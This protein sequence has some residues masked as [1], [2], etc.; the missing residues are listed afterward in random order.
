L[1]WSHIRMVLFCTDFTLSRIWWNCF[2][3]P[4]KTPGC[5]L[6]TVL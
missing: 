4:G 5:I 1:S 2:Y 6:K 3:L